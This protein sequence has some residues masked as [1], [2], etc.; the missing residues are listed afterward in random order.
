VLVDEGKTERDGDG[1]AP[2]RDVKS[3]DS[4]STRR[5]AGEGL[6]VGWEVSGPVDKR[7]FRA[8]CDRGFRV[9]SLL[10]RE[11]FFSALCEVFVCIRE[12]WSFLRWPDPG[13]AC[14]FALSSRLG[15]D[16]LAAT[17]CIW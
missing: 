3:V 17:R 16:L 2:N 5:G 12:F 7:V 14:L 8:C 9:S 13:F 11:T 10:G 6:R 1:D 15:L 4:R